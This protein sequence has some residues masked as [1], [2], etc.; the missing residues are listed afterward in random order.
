MT[1][2]AKSNLATL[3]NESQ[4]LNTKQQLD[5]KGGCGTRSG[6][7]GGG[8][9]GGYSGGSYSGGCSSTPPATTPP[10]VT[11]PPIVH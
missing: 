2:T 7:W 11:P 4:K 10:P 6:S 8:N 9:W 1:K 5:L 3:L